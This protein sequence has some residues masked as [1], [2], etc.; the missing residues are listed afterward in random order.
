MSLFH[1]VM[2]IGS[3]DVSATEYGYILTHYPS[4]NMAG[5]MTHVN[6]FGVIVSF[7]ML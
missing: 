3:M 2:R 5:V 1:L 7:K 6:C 4:S